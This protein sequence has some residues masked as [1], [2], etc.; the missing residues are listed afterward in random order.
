VTVAVAEPYRLRATALGLTF[1]PLV[2][3]EEHERLLAHPDFWH[4]LKAG[5]HCARWGA[6]LIARQYEL[7]N[8]LT[9]TGRAVLVANPGVLAAL[10][11][12]E[13]RRIPLV[14]L[15]LQPWMLPSSLA[16]SVMPGPAPPRWAPRQC[17]DLYWRGLDWVGDLLVGREF[18]RVRTSAGLRPSRRILSNWLSRELVLG[19]FPEWYGPPPADWPKQVRL[20]GF[21]LFEGGGTG[22]APEVL[23][24]CAEGAPPVVCT[25]GTGM[26]HGARV[27][28]TA[29]EA[30]RQIGARCLLLTRHRAQLPDTLPSFARFCEF[31]PLRELLPRCAAVVHHGGIGTVATACATATPQLL[32]PFAYD[33]M[34][35]AARIKR[36]GVGEGIDSRRVTADSLAR[37]LRRIT[38]PATKERCRKVTAQFSTSDPLGTSASCILRLFNRG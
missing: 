15:V 1:R 6:P 9:R 12:H 24:F 36:L 28:R 21:P 29:L 26:M 30:G 17:W 4:P 5:L 11:V 31:A 23:S 34:D 10:I 13:A 16:P 27:F 7:L 35:N 32:L 33:Q 20:V 3:A 8:E 38:S 25:F 37:A 2:S 14:N 22:L 18:N 19:M